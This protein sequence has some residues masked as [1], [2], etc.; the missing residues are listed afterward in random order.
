VSAVVRAASLI[1]VVAAAVVAVTIFGIPWYRYPDSAAVTAWFWLSEPG[2]DL[3]L[4]GVAAAVALTGLV[5][6]AALPR[7]LAIVG[8]LA[9]VGLAGL[10]ISQLVDPLDIGVGNPS[11]EPGAIAA[12]VAAACLVAAS[13][14]AMSAVMVPRKTCPDCAERV[15][16]RADNCPHCGHRFPL[17]R[18]WKRCPECGGKIR[19]EARVCKHCQARLSDEPVAAGAGP[20]AGPKR[21]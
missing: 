6:G 11:I 9:S 13:L 1:A 2:L 21:A 17:A 5:V 10:I 16:A 19:A 8:A 18:G 14:T 7:P 20:N 12:L 3:G 15:P 4:A